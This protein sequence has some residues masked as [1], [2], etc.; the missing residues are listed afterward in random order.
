M[1]V[2]SA[3]HIVHFICSSESS[4]Q[5][6]GSGEEVQ[7][8]QPASSAL[9]Y[10]VPTH[11]TPPAQHEAQHTQ[12][13]QTAVEVASQQHKKSSR[14][15]SQ[16]AAGVH[17]QAPCTWWFSPAQHAPQSRSQEQQ[18]PLTEVTGKQHVAASSQQ[19]ANA[20]VKCLAHGTLHLQCLQ[21]HTDDVQ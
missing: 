10:Q 16:Q 15:T 2:S 3:L 20:G 12:G 7:H 9:Y 13:H 14:K 17:C 19:A 4:T 11:V 5:R 18:S 21:Q 8:V 1:R 6:V